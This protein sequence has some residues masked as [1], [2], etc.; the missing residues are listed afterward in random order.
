[1]S[2]TNSQKALIYFLNKQ[3]APLQKKIK[4]KDQVITQ[5]KTKINELT[6]TTFYMS[7]GME[8]DRVISI[9]AYEAYMDGE[10]E[11]QVQEMFN[12]LDGCEHNEIMMDDLSKNHGDI[13][14]CICTICGTTIGCD[15]E[16]TVHTKYSRILSD[17]SSTLKQK[18]K[19]VMDAYEIYGD[20]PPYGY[21]LK[22]RKGMLEDFCDGMKFVIE[23]YFSNLKAEPK[24]EIKAPFREGDSFLT[25]LNDIIYQVHY[26]EAALKCKAYYIHYLMDK[27]MGLK[28]IKVY[29][30]YSS[31]QSN[32][33][34]S[35]TKLNGEYIVYDVL[36]D[37]F[38]T[39]NDLFGDYFDIYTVVDEFKYLPEWVKDKAL[40]KFEPDRNIG[41]ILDP[42][43]EDSMFKLLEWCSS[44]SSYGPSKEL[45]LVAVEK[46]Y[47]ANREFMQHNIAFGIKVLGQIYDYMLSDRYYHHGNKRKVIL[48]KVKNMF[49][50]KKVSP[51]QPKIIWSRLKSDL[52]QER[53]CQIKTTLVSYHPIQ[54]NKTE[55]VNHMKLLFHIINKTLS[56]KRKLLVTQKLFEVLDRNTWFLEEEKKFAQAMVNKL[57]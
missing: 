24:V 43:V 45:L 16:K 7:E 6:S 53:W 26:L 55:V 17:E 34:I 32:Y 33:K 13:S 4:R 12:Q 28:R 9:S 29:R 11:N 44:V 22:L 25:E 27:C 50:R 47:A 31:S 18:N 41:L 37:I 10:A 8:Y 35:T 57:T 19:A 5:F 56:S 48:Q 42:R 46:L 30:S 51:D 23:E 20:E 15:S 39:I 38:Y 40:S 49:L 2:N 52:S 1:M 36:C 54:Y 3:L 14:K 21:S